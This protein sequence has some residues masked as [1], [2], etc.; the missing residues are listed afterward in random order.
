MAK[1]REKRGFSVQFLGFF[2]DEKLVL[3]ALLA[4]KNRVA[5]I[6]GGPCGDIAKFANFLPEL[7]AYLRREKVIFCQITPHFVVKKLSQDGEI[8]DEKSLNLPLPVSRKSFSAQQT[9][10]FVKTFQSN[11]LETYNQSARRMLKK[12]EANNLQ[13]TE[14][15]FDEI[16]ELLDETA[17]RQHFATKG[18]NYYHLLRESF[19]EKARFIGVKFDDKVVAGGVFILD[20]SEMIYLFGGSKKEFANTGAPTF[21]Q[22]YAMKLAHELGYKKY[23]FYGVSGKFDGSDNVL[24]F[25]QAF[26]GQIEQFSPSYDFVINKP[27]YFLRNLL[28]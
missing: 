4:A 25:K 21:L 16:V 9:F 27:A 3:V 14:D 22:D 8:T 24:K 1:L 26:R 2:E 20:K 15:N 28:R 19:G 17:T 12:A 7:K 23:N 6:D 18:E 5:N 10:Q 11:L 13:I